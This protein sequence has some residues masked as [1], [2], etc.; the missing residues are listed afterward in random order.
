MERGYFNITS[1]TTTTL[2]EQYNESGAISFISVANCSSSNAVTITLYYDD[3]TNQLSYIENL[4]I[5]VGCTLLLDKGLSFDNDV[6]SLKLTTTG[7]S[8]DVNVII[9]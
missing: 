8:P 6:F 1:A 3:A 5:P 2:I 9:K 4:V 7:T